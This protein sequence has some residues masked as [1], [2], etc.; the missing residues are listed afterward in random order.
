[1]KRLKRFLSIWDG[2]WSFPVAFI[3]FLGFGFLGQLIFGVNFGFYD[4]SFFQAALMAGGVFVLFNFLAWFGLYFNFRS[5]FKYFS[6]EKTDEGSFSNKSKED[7]KQLT[8]W[9][10]IVLSLFMYCFFIVVLV[11]IFR[12]LV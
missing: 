4:P 2:L 9:Q 10:R 1:M 5:V 6:G 11:V 3:I 8:P 7:A 12:A